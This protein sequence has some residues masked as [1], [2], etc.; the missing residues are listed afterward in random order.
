MTSRS[1]SGAASQASSK[2]QPAK[3][4]LITDTCAFLPCEQ[5]ETCALA[6][7]C[8]V[9]RFPQPKVTDDS[10]GLKDNAPALVGT[11]PGRTNRDPALI[12]R[13]RKPLTR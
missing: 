10:A 2:S 6:K 8:V 1:N 3:R 5:V 7:V 11:K 12:Q 9:K 13:K 4:V